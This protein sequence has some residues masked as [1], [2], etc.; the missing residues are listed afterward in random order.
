ML[1]PIKHENM[2]ARRWPFI[3]LGLILANF[4]VFLCTHYAM[5][6]QEDPLLSVKVHVLVL[7]AQHPELTV[8]PEVQQLVT[9]FQRYYPAD[10]AEMQA[11]NDK[12]IESGD[13]HRIESAD[14]EGELQK[15]MDAFATEYS[16]LKAASI[17]ERYAFIPARPKLVA[18][19]S[20]MFLHE[21]WLHLIGNMWFLWLAGFVLEDVWGRPL[22]LAFYLLA[23]FAGTQLYAWSDPGSLGASFGASG[24]VAGLMG[25]FLVRFPKLKIR[26]VWLFDFGLFG[27]W[28]LWVRAYWLLP[29]WAGMEIYYGGAAGQGD[30]VAHWAHV[31]GFMFGAL[32]ALA[33]RYS[34]LEHKA[35]KAI[36]NK[37]SWTTDPEINQASDLI[38]KGKLDEAAV[39][40][41]KNLVEDPD[42][43]GA[44]NM[45]RAIHWQRNEIP[46]C[47]DVAGK[48]CVL[49]IEAKMYEAAW[50]D[51]EEFLNMGGDKMPPAVWLELCRVPEERNDFKRALSEYEK[52]AAAYP[53]ERQ[54]LMAQLGAARI[55]LTR[56][57]RPDE[58]LRLYE[59]V[60][61]S[62]VPHLDLESDIELG[63]R[64]AKIALSR[65]VSMVT[66]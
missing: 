49:N 32:T 33:L 38:E 34:D 14:D 7:A 31:G 22:Y 44:W 48:L 62:A 54:G 43:L 64:E 46:A 24:A 23:G 45:L 28:P 61:A 30:G 56:L 2:A 26:L 53:A 6:D 52:L 39:I 47:R 57:H 16:K 17:T 13:I 63:M 55:L 36:E 1:F 59:A 11:P 51:Y 10:W 29:I 50:L 4:V 3:T 19:F 40:L 37:V 5:E 42:S 15:E 41:N 66:T 18:Y 25:A 20:A 12:V 58:A 60:S 9:D 27:F 21:G 65:R 35:N 8:P